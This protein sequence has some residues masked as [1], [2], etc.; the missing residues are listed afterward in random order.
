MYIIGV[1]EVE[2]KE[3]RKEVITK[4]KNGGQ[5]SKLIKDMNSDFQEIQSITGRIKGNEQ[6]GTMQ[7][8]YNANKIS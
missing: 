6:Q 4:L 3:N 5:F 8:N 1:L 7:E 2:N